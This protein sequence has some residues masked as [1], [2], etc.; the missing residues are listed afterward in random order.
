MVGGCVFFFSVC[1]RVY[2]PSLY[3]VQLYFVVVLV[4]CASPIPRRYF[5]RDI[6]V[7]HTL[8]YKLYSLCIYDKSAENATMN[9]C[10]CLC[11]A[12]ALNRAPERLLLQ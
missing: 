7:Y 1:A 2:I 5:A 6:S 8:L 12:S 9:V 4:P 11:L 10:W 3:A